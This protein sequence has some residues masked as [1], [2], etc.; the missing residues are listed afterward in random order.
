MHTQVLIIGDTYCR[1]L[2]NKPFSFD[3]NMRAYL[4]SNNVTTRPLQMLFYQAYS[5]AY[6]IPTIILF[7]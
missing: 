3:C 7:Q 2:G 5:T 4:P 6:N 1:V